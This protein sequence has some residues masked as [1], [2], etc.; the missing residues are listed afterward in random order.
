M[1]GTQAFRLYN[2]YTSHYDDDAALLLAER[3][4]CTTVAYIQHRITNLLQRLI[5]MQ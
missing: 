4:T 3:T 1:F 2:L 5:N